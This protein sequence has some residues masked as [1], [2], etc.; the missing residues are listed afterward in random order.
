MVKWLFSA[1]NCKWDDLDGECFP[2]PNA[3]EE[4]KEDEPEKENESE[5][6]NKADGT[7]SETNIE[8]SSAFRFIQNQR[9]FRTISTVCTTSPLTMMKSFLAS[10]DIWT[11]GTN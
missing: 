7:D 10:Y 6:E 2:D 3:E 9:Y 5:D 8:V 1:N 11:S 4:E